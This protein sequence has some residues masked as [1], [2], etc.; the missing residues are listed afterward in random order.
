MEIALLVSGISGILS[1]SGA[2]ITGIITKYGYAAIF[3]LMAM[4]GS[5]LPI[6]SEVILPIAG[7]FVA[8]GVLNI[9][10]TIIVATLGSALGFAIDYYIGYYLGKDVVYKHLAFFHLKKADLDSFDK[11]FERN[12]VIAIFFTRM[13]PVLR[14]VINFPA[15]FARM[16]KKK[17]FA[18]SL[19]GALIWNTVLTIF[20]VYLL[21]V[22]NAELA[23]GAIGAFAIVLY[24]IYAIAKKYMR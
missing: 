6:P 23:M 17:F 15:G 10:L 16:P 18:Y 2:V 24:L 7:L 9:Y 22:K 12:G 14:T 21:S 3:V 11:W 19:A 5:T 8:K 4:E 20:G 1:N 13:I